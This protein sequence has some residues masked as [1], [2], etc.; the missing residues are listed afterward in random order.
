MSKIIEYCV[1][2]D[3]IQEA[4]GEAISDDDELVGLL[5]GD[6]VGYDS[7]ATYIED[8]FSVT[9]VTLGDNGEVHV[10]FR[11]E[12]E[13]LYGCRDMCKTDLDEKTVVGEIRGGK[14]VLRVPEYER[15]TTVDEF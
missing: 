4:I 2:L 13:A 1:G 7:R 3:N 15:R 5:I 8:S 12:W 11:F 10:S 14:L 9:E 6:L